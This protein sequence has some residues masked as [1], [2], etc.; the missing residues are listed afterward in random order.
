[1]ESRHLTVNG[2]SSASGVQKSSIRLFVFSNYEYFLWF[3]SILP[4]CC[5]QN[6]H[7]NRLNERGDRSHFSCQALLGFVCMLE[8]ESVSSPEASHLNSVWEWTSCQSSTWGCLGKWGI[9]QSAAWLGG[10]RG[11]NSLQYLTQHLLNA[12]RSESEGQY[13]GTRGRWTGLGGGT[14]MDKQHLLPSEW[15]PSSKNGNKLAERHSLNFSF[16]TPPPPLSCSKPI[17]DVLRKNPPPT[18]TIS[19]PPN[20]SVCQLLA[21]TD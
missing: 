20:P 11:C 17:Q 10:W 21:I 5:R 14:K 16:I 4:S 7:K 19:H 3:S 12:L 15:N 1:M 2:N 8:T 13:E 6:A 18:T 9:H